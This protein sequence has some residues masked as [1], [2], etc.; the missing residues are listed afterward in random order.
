MAHDRIRISIISDQHKRILATVLDQ[1]IGW[2]VPYGYH[3]LYLRHIEA[4]LNGRFHDAVF[5][6]YFH[7]T[8]KQNQL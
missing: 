1:S 5:L 2:T 3:K 7:Q 6:A 4:N 8:A